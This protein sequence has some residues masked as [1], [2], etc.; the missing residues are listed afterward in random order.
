[1]ENNDDTD[2]AKRRRAEEASRILRRLDENPE[3]LEAQADKAAF[4]SRGEAERKTY[5]Y[6]EKA[7]AAA[8]KGLRNKDRRYMIAVIGALLA[9]MYFG[10]EPLRIT[11]LADHQ[12]GLEPRRTVL[13]SGDGAVLDASTALQDETDGDVRAVRVLRG[14]AFF[15]V[16]SETRSFVVASGDVQVTVVGTSFEVASVDDTIS[17]SVVEGRVDV[18]S[19]DTSISLGEGERGIISNLGLARET[20][21]LEDIALWRQ[22]R[23]SITGLSFSEAASLVE[24]RLPGRVVVVGGRLAAMEVGGNLN[25]ADP[26]SALEALAASSDAEVLQASRLLTIIYSQ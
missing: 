9:S 15:D 24:R 6:L 19:G 7:Y 12:T 4:L 11:V 25:L 10:W 13:A 14:T 23:L 20:V 1:M 2:S 8:R 18:R 26:V 22:N 17:V 3:D 21:A 16:A 5:A